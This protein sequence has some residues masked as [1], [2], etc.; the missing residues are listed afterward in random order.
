ML[1]EE[2]LKVLLE[3]PENETEAEWRVR[4]EKKIDVI[5]SCIVI[6]QKNAAEA[7]GVSPDTVRDK[8]LRGEIDV[9][10][11]DGSRLNYLTLEDVGELKVRTKRKRRK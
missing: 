5:L 6:Q 11:R 1:R 4:M 2:A 10:Q 3:S 7:V 9:L 8:V